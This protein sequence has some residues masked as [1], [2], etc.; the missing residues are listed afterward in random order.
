MKANFFSCLPMLHYAVLDMIQML[1]FLFLLNMQLVVKINTFNNL[2]ITHV[3]QIY[4]E[5][6]LH[7]IFY[8]QTDFILHQTHDA[9]FNDVKRRDAMQRVA[10]LT[11]YASH[12]DQIILSIFF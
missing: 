2:K 7:L 8:N 5:T 1:F 11:S 6:C 3:F 10:V 9:F 12:W 4:C